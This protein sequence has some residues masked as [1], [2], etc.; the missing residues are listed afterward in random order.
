VADVT[1]K[2]FVKGKAR[3]PSAWAEDDAAAGRL[4][5]VS[6]ELVGSVDR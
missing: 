5:A 4:W 1:G 3:K 2:Y 6:E